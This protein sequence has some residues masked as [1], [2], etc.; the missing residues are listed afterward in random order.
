MPVHICVAECAWNGGY[1]YVTGGHPFFEE[2]PLVE[3]MHRVFTR[4]AGESCHRR[5]RSLLLY[6]C[7]VF[8][9]LINTFVCWFYIRKRLSQSQWLFCNPISAVLVWLIFS[10]FVF[11][12]V[13]G[14]LT[15]LLSN[16]CHCHAGGRVRSAKCSFV[17][18]AGRNC[19]FSCSWLVMEHHQ[20]RI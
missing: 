7:Y 12:Y 3:F 19:T 20:Q 11:W 4:M 5:L 17:L 10:L 2:V 14:F 13:C 8:R 6:L 18:Q 9:A 15:V 1:I 16:N